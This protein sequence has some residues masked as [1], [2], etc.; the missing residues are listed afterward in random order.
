[1]DAKDITTSL[2]GHWQGRFGTA[3]C[4]ICQGER[5]K[6]QNALTLTDGEDGRLLAHCKKSGCD[7]VDIISALGLRGGGYVAPTPHEMA[8]RKAEAEA[9]REKA[10]ERC[11]R[12]W[13]RS[14]PIAG[15][16]G[17]AYL[18]GRGISVPIPDCL[19]W[20]A[21][22][23][24]SPT[25]RWVSAIVARVEPT[26][27]LHRTFLFP[28]GT[29]DKLMLGPCSGGAVRLAHGS[30][31]LLV[32][33]GIENTLSAMQLLGRPDLSAW[34]ALSTS[35]LRSVVLPEPPGELIVA[36][37]GDAPGRAAGAELAERATSLGWSVSIADPGDC[38]DWNDKLAEGRSAA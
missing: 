30:G 12:V 33:E 16:K 21:D 15:T 4:P 11:K 28:D 24:H 26:G 14:T 38:L 8:A 13:E 25:G 36:V 31:A 35:G 6:G 37:D 34:A 23:L 32:G 27:G 17:E 18:R 22:I 29:K 7:F 5:L 9:E 2:G 3:P 1:M 10:L 19:R 20:R